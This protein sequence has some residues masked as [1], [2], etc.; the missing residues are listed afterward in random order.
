MQT[1]NDSHK[2]PVSYYG[3]KIYYINPLIA[4]KAD[5]AKKEPDY[6]TENVEE[7]NDR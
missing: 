1:D 2:Q 5:K 3:K 6:S 4:K 7:G